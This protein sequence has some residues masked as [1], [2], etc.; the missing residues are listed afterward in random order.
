M[1]RGL[2]HQG[3]KQSMLEYEILGP[4]CCC[5]FTYEAAPLQ[6]RDQCRHKGSPGSSKLAQNCDTICFG[7]AAL[8]GSIIKAW[9]PAVLENLRCRCRALQFE[10]LQDE[11]AGLGLGPVIQFG[12]FQFPI[13]LRGV[14]KE[15]QPTP[16]HTSTNLRTEERLFQ[17]EKVPF[18][19]GDCIAY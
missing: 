2:I 11:I 18:K 15:F 5:I 14:Q 16:K 19:Q 10:A 6:R 17:I 13:S 4:D 7:G 9:Y 3:L 12:F 8:N 1:C